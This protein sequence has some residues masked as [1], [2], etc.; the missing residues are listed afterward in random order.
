MGLGPSK[1]LNGESFRCREIK[2]K[3]PTPIE[4]EWGQFKHKTSGRCI[5]GWDGRVF[6]EDCNLN[7]PYRVWRFISSNDGEGNFII[8]H[9]A[10]ELCMDGNGDNVYLGGCSKENAWMNWKPLKASDGNWILQHKATGKCIDGN[11]EAVYF[12]GCDG[13]NSFQNFDIPGNTSGVFRYDDLVKKRRLYPNEAIA[14]SWDPKWR[15]TNSNDDDQV[16]FRCGNQKLPRGLDM[17]KYSNY[18]SF[19]GYEWKESDGG[20]C[21]NK[22]WQPSTYDEKDPGALCRQECDNTESCSGYVQGKWG[23][24]T[25][26]GLYARNLVSY[27]GEQGAFFV[28]N[29]FPDDFPLKNEKKVE[30]YF[31]T[32]FEEDEDT[33]KWEMYIGNYPQLEFMG[34]PVGAKKGRKRDPQVESMKIPDGY[35]VKIYSKSDYNGPSLKLTGNIK[36]L[37]DLGFYGPVKSIKIYKAENDL[38]EVEVFTDCDYKGDRY[39]I[40]INA[41]YIEISDVRNVGIPNDEISSLKVP[42]GYRVELY[43]HAGYQGKGFAVR[44]N[45]SCLNTESIGTEFDK[46]TT[47]LKII[48]G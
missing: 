33:K 11:G 12:G 45:V 20:N 47:A 29:K 18:L 24:C 42:P 34:L 2:K 35:K 13:G 7:D 1:P 16:Y 14:D 22:Y 4:V 21:Y 31:Q 26:Y 23:C 19:V 30:L 43:Q 17:A 48:R 39:G 9:K 46:E 5:N 27:T 36:N 37:S 3:N 44:G 38:P 32:D 8:Q 6:F 28:K 41:D 15:E 25:K 10:T 40:D